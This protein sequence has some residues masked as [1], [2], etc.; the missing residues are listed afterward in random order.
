[1]AFYEGLLGLPL[2]AVVTHDRVPSTQE[3]CTYYHIFFELG[4]GSYLAFFDLLD[5]KATV[6]D[7]Q[8][9]GW[10][11]HLALELADIES[12]RAAH[13]RLK[14]AGVEVTEPVDHGWFVSIY[15]RDPNG[16]RLELV[17]RTASLEE[18]RGKQRQARD[19]LAGRRG[20]SATRIA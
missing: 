15:F 7:P 20:R 8:T 14:S 17:V 10:V 4:D 18:M 11:N 6:P 2:A 12:L 5:G 9:P 1:M 13:R 16:I 3:S 19:I